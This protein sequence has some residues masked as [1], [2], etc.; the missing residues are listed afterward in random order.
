MKTSVISVFILT[1]LSTSL[2]GAI[3]INSD[4]GPALSVV[5]EVPDSDEPQAVPG[6]DSLSKIVEGVSQSRYKS[7]LRPRL[8]TVRRHA[9]GSLKFAQQATGQEALG[10]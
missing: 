10:K 7:Q 4:A 6:E 9:T 8:I 5:P 3:P 2:A 1:F